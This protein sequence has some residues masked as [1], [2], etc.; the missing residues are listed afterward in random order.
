MFVKVFTDDDHIQKKKCFQFCHSMRLF[1]FNLFILSGF[2]CA[3]S[4][5]SWFHSMT[6]LPW[7]QESGLDTMQHLWLREA[8]IDLSN[9][10]EYN[11]T[12]GASKQKLRKNEKDKATYR[13]DFWLDRLSTQGFVNCIFIM[14]KFWISVD[15]YSF[16]FFIAFKHFCKKNLIKS[17]YDMYWRYFVGFKPVCIIHS[18]FQITSFFCKIFQQLC[19]ENM[20]RTISCF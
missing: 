17:N 19:R 6:T 2:T 8:W 9:S 11:E 1:I 14:G 7:P 5:R 15:V 20:I 16:T 18:Q 3:N 12:W 13:L 10:L 4:G